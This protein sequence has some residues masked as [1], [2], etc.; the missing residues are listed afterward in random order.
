MEGHPGPVRT[1]GLIELE[2]KQTNPG[3]LIL[4]QVRE[5]G[6]VKTSENNMA[7]LRW[8]K[9]REG[10]EEEVLWMSQFRSFCKP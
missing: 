8:V 3:A 2:N 1:C 7:T 6:K 9:R 4:S 5:K 10:E